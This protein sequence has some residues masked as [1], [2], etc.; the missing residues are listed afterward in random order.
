M[1]R[2]CCIIAQIDYNS[3]HSGP[4][5]RF[6]NCILRARPAFPLIFRLQMS[7]PMAMAQLPQFSPRAHGCVCV[8][9]VNELFVTAVHLM[10]ANCAAQLSILWCPVCAVRVCGPA[11]CFQLPHAGGGR[12]SALLR[13]FVCNWRDPILSVLLDGLT[14]VCGCCCGS[15]S[16]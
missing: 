3:A 11:I 7:F 2:L 5:G 4:F 16:F 13:P 14:D 15:K 9:E 12:K 10:T 8:L 1:P 6:P